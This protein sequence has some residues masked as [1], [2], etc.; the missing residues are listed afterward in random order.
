MSLDQL[1]VATLHVSGGLV[2]AALLAGAMMRR[3]A[4]S[5]ATSRGSSSRWCACACAGAD[6]R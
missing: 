1:L 6:L 2:V 3:I 5:S 4:P